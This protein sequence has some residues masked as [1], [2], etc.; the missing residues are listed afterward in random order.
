MGPCVSP[1]YRG[2]PVTASYQLARFLSRKGTVLD[3]VR[4][5]ITR[6]RLVISITAR[7]SEHP[8]AYISWADLIYCQLYPGLIFGMRALPALKRNVSRSR[9]L[10]DNA[11]CCARDRCADRSRRGV[12]SDIDD[13]VS[14]RTDRVGVVQRRTA[15]HAAADQRRC[16]RHS[17]H[18][19]T[20]RNELALHRARTFRRGRSRLPADVFDG[21]SRCELVARVIDCGQLGDDLEREPFAEPSGRLLFASAPAGVLFGVEPDRLVG[22]LISQ[23]VVEDDRAAFDEFLARLPLPS[24]GPQSHTWRLRRSDGG[25]RCVES[26]GLDLVREST[27]GGLVLNVRDVTERLA[28]EDRLRQAQKLEV[29]GHLAAGVAHDFNNVLATI[30][31][32]AE[33]AQLVLDKNHEAQYDLTQIR[34]A[35]ARGA[36]LT[37]RL[38]TFVR[39]QPVPP[40]WI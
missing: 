29:V 14:R 17:A 2:G 23:W 39:L 9:V 1:R 15:L 38:L 12:R 5:R 22:Q 8:L 10:V 3:R 33:L 11:G 20:S 6:S 34:A 21:L 36:A 18:T 24:T 13:H 4:L 28:L 19:I 32:S 30:L 37:R 35:A 40:S 25:I 16:G 7:L 27:V 31:S 26:V